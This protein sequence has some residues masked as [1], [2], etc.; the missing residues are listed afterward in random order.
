[1]LMELMEKNGYEHYEISNFCLP[2]KI[3]K[4]NSAYWTGEKYLGIGP[5][6][7]SFDGN[8]RQ[9]N[10]SNIKAYVDSVSNGTLSFE[11][12]VLSDDQKFNEFVLTSLRTMWGVDLHKMKADFGIKYYN[13]FI[14]NLK[15]MTE[16]GQLILSDEKAMLSRQGKFFA[17]QVASELFCV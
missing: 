8:S 6:A 9:W 1:M 15:P 3:S 13:H 10:V 16:K 7:H 11:K 12:E 4:H 5:S 17:D 14:L 2:G